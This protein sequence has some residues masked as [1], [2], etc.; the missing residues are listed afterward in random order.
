MLM[1]LGS[2]VLA[3]KAAL[4]EL[5]DE[6]RDRVVVVDAPLVEGVVAQA[7]VASQSAMTRATADS[8]PV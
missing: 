4:F 8:R 2:S 7:M 3:V 6:Q 5:E 1:D